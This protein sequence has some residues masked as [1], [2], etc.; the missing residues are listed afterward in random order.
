MHKGKLRNRAA[1]PRLGIFD[2]EW[3][4]AFD[5]RR[6]Y[7][8]DYCDHHEPKAAGGVL[9]AA[10]M[11]E[12]CRK[13][14]FMERVEDNLHGGCD[15][16]TRVKASWRDHAYRVEVIGHVFKF[17]YDSDAVLF[18]LRFMGST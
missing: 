18:A 1:D 12:D 17:D 5:E 3:T 8:L 14:V 4:V 2:V 7:A 16:F 6:H 11:L 10:G 9:V 13:W 15:V